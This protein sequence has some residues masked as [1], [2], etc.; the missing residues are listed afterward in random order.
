MNQRTEHQRNVPAETSFDQSGHVRIYN[1]KIHE[2]FKIHS[3]IGLYI[4]WS[5]PY[6]RHGCRRYDSIH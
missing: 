6:V 4:P 3:L 5:H 1:Y 2:Y